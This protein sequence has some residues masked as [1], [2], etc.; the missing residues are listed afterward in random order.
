MK[1]TPTL[2]HRRSRHVRGVLLVPARASRAT[3]G[4]LVDEIHAHPRH[5]PRPVVGSAAL[6]APPFAAASA[7]RYL[8]SCPPD[9]DV[10]HI[11][12]TSD[13]HPSFHAG[14]PGVA[15]S[16]G[17][18]RLKYAPAAFGVPARLGTETRP[19]SWATPAYD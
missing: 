16:K 9:R 7:V 3:T 10:S 2:L 11:L 4:V 15:R 13:D 1:T 14:H 18:C 6:T 5:S 17:K 8:P 19:I 12:F